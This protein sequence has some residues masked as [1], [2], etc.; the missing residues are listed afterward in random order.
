MTNINKKKFSSMLN[1]AAVLTAAISDKGLVPASQVVGFANQ[2]LPLFK[3][4]NSSLSPSAAA[5]AAAAEPC[6]LSVGLP[7]TTPLGLRGRAR[8]LVF[9]QKKGSQIPNPNIISYN[10]QPVAGSN[11][12]I[13]TV[14]NINKL[15]TNNV[16]KLLFNF[17]KSMY[18]LIS[19]PVFITTPD[20]IK[21]QLFYFVCL[22]KILINQTVA[23]ANANA[24]KINKPTLTSQAYPAAAAASRVKNLAQSNLT[25][26]YPHK[27]KLICTILSKFFNK[28]V[29]LELIRLHQPYYDSNILV[30]FLAL[31]INKKNIGACIQRLYNRNIIKSKKA[32]SLSDLSPKASLDNI[33]NP[34]PALGSSLAYPYPS[35]TGS[36]FAAAAAAAAAA[37]E[38]ASNS[39]TA[40]LSGLNIKISGRLMRE[41]IIPRI[42]SKKFEKGFTA[43]GK[44]NYSDLARFTHKNRKGAFTITVK[45]GQNF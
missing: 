21:I 7:H 22:P 9:L 5:A 31:I 20:K 33:Y 36:S 16:Y 24:N 34:S 37:G 3:N 23:S 26:V 8:Q 38:G 14:Y 13:N 18:C 39:T 45:S 28:T 19:K 35:S 12:K 30:N 2:R 44:I 11:P 43:K 42:T 17:F 10:F 32:S 1:P 6:P 29:E 15:M 41:P 25:K 40:Y 27:F 4:P